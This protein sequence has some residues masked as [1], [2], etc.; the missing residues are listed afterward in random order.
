MRE[1]RR[2]GILLVSSL[3]AL[4]G[5]SLTAAYNATKSFDLILAEGLWH[6]LA[7]DG[8]DVLGALVGATRTPSMLA[9]NPA[10]E[11]FPSLM[12][13]VDVAEGALQALGEGPVW[14]AGAHNQALAG[15]LLPVSRV[16]IV[17][18]MSR[19]TAE[20]YRLPFSEASGRD[21]GEL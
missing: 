1:R 16:G 19:A 17:S 2:G 11:D 5:S 6:E 3:A 14:V 4:A 18:A 21:F 8:I 12:E 15:S 20:L 13:P 10:F 9:S 7:P